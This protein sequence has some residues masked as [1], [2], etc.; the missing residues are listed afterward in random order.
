MSPNTQAA[1]LQEQ[2]AVITRLAEAEG[3]TTR[4][5]IEAAEG[6]TLLRETLVN[7]YRVYQDQYNLIS[8]EVAQARR[9]RPKRRQIPHSHYTGPYYEEGEEGS[10]SL[11]RRAPADP[12][13]PRRRA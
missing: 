6:L 1:I 13:T 11:S 10:V 7:L 12:R 8:A 2:A 3:Q 9:G 5:T 4:T